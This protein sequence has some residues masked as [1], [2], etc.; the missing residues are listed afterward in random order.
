MTTLRTP[1]R[2]PSPHDFH[3]GRHIETAWSSTVA[4]VEVLLSLRVSHWTF[5]GVRA[6]TTDMHWDWTGEESLLWVFDDDG[7][8]KVCQGLQSQPHIL[9]TEAEADY[10][11]ESIIGRYL[12]ASGHMY[13]AVKWRGF[14]CPT[15]EEEETL[16]GSYDEPNLTAMLQ[17]C[18]ESV[19]SIYSPATRS[20][21]W[22]PL[23][24]A[25]CI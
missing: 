23:E 18:A 21:A 5:L 14:Q 3:R 13:L 2:G 25:Q 1:V 17:S 16:L 12:S 20:S 22:S 10:G 24:V 19:P 4:V 7:C 6:E 11:I 15:W 8:L 9:A